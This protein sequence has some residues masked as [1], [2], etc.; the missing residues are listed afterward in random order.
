MGFS[1]LAQM[2]LQTTQQRYELERKHRI[3]GDLAQFT[4]EQYLDVTPDSI[5]GFYDFVNVDGTMPVDRFAQANLWQQLL[6]QGARFPQIMQ[7]YDIPKIFGWVA[8]LSGLK[9]VNRFRIN[10][11]PDAQMQQQAQ[12]GNSVPLRPTNPEAAPNQMQMPGMGAAM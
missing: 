5:A 3:V 7:G 8:A 9:N 4:P 1:P 10:V 11:V 2:M 12:A 6:G